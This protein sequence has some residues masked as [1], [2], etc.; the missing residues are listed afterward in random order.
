MD[1]TSSS[2]PLSATLLADLSSESGLFFDKEVFEFS[3]AAFFSAAGD[4]TTLLVDF[5]DVLPAK[6]ESCENSKQIVTRP[7]LYVCHKRIRIIIYK[8]IRFE[9]SKQ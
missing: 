9:G 7:D 2:P 6:K 3:T 4:A 5:P 8:K 1:S